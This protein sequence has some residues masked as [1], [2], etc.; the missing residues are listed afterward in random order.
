MILAESIYDG[1]A[2]FAGERVD[3][4]LDDVRDPKSRS[5]IVY[6]SPDAFL[7]LAKAGTD[8]GKDER[9]AAIMRTV[10]K[11][12][13]LPLLYFISKD[14]DF[15]GPGYVSGHEGRHRM[16]WLRAHGVTQVPVELRSV[17][18]LRWGENPV[19]P[20][21]L[22]SEDGGDVVRMPVSAIYP[23]EG[24]APSPSR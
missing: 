3:A 2:F 5:T 14:N 22:V 1:D 11:F 17:S 21:V 12:S 10:G 4:V 23:G 16:R 15:A 7:T 20:S 9:I 6:L 19:R 24:T 8:R 18:G 13:S